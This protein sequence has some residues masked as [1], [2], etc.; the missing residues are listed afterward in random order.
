MRTLRCCVASLAFVAGAAWAAEGELPWDKQLAE[1]GYHIVFTSSLN[2]ING[3]QL[4]MDQAATLRQLA[5]GIEKVSSQPPPDTGSFGPRLQP[6]RSTFRDLEALLLKGDDMPQE[7]ETRV[8][9]ARMIEAAEIRASLEL[10]PARHGCAKCHADPAQRASGSQQL[11]RTAFNEREMGFAHLSGPFGLVGTA[12]ALKASAEIERILTPSQLSL[13]G[14][15]TCC[16]TPPRN[17]KDPARVGQAVVSENRLELLRNVRKVPA[18]V[19]PISRAVIVKRLG[20]GL[21]AARPGIPEA[22][23]KANLELAGSVLDQ[24][25]ALSDVDFE[26]QKED[27]ARQLDPRAA[28]TQ[29]SAATPPRPSTHAAWFLLLPGSTRAYDALIERLKKGETAAATA[30]VDL[31]TIKGAANCQDGKCALPGEGNLKPGR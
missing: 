11:D 30:Q 19:W 16:L 27:L 10:N 22:A 2:L 7:L 15:F 26:L 5:G 17:L 25:R 12:R 28:L 18:G 24:A 1:L 21:S 14:D 13:L 31:N 6:V 20:D 3:L 8:R 9:S 29:K 23:K 4:T